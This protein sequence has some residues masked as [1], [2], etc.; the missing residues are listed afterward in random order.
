MA[1]PLGGAASKS[2]CFEAAASLAD[3]TRIFRIFHQI[4]AMSIVRSVGAVSGLA[5]IPP[6]IPTLVDK[7]PS[8]PGWIHEVKQDGYRMQLLV[9]V[10]NSRLL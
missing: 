8:G 9:E 2:R 1:S 6:M 3:L 10:G 7:P 4:W 5:F